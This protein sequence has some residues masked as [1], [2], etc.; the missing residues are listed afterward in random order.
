MHMAT[1]KDGVTATALLDYLDATVRGDRDAPGFAGRVCF[2]IRTAQGPRWW[3]AELGKRATTRFV[4]AR[5]EAFDVAVALDD[6][7]A[8]SLVGLPVQRPPLKLISGS[9]RVLARFV[10]RYLRKPGGGVAWSPWDVK[11]TRR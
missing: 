2:G 3:V 4:A 5:P 7:G 10:R 6:Q 8:R 9:G 1:T 11:E